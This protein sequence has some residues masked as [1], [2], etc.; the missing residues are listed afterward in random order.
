MHREPVKTLKHPRL[1]PITEVERRCGAGL[2]N[3]ITDC[4][5]R[6]PSPVSLNLRFGIILCSL[7]VV[8]VGLVI[9]F[10]TYSARLAEEQFVRQG[11]AIAASL[12]AQSAVDV[13]MRDRG[14]LTE[15]LDAWINSGVISGGVLHGPGGS[16]LARRNFQSSSPPARSDLRRSSIQWTSDSEEGHLLIA[17][18]PVVRN[19]RHLGSVS[20]TISASAVAAQRDAGLWM[21]LIVSA[22]LT[23]LTVI[24]LVMLN[25][26]VVRPLVALRR[27][28]RSAASGE[29]PIRIE[30]YA[31]DEVGQLA[32]WFDEMIRARERDIR[33]LQDQS[34]HVSQA[35]RRSEA[36]QRKT[37][38]EAA[39]L[40]NQFDRLAEITAHVMHG[41][42]TRHLEVERD[43]HVGDLMHQINAMVGDLSRMISRIHH[44]AHRMTT[45]AVSV[46]SSAEVMS[47]GARDQSVRACTLADN[48]HA[49][50]D[51]A[52]KVAR[53]VS[54]VSEQA[55]SALDVSR[56]SL[57]EC[58]ASADVMRRVRDSLNTAADTAGAVNQSAK[59][60]FDALSA[61]SE[62]ADQIN[63]LAFNAAIEAA[64]AGDQGRGFSVVADQ[65]TKV[66]ERATAAVKNISTISD[67]LRRDASA[68]IEQTTRESEE[69][70][71]ALQSVDAV[72]EA[73]V[74]LANTIP[75]LEDSLNRIAKH[76][77]DNAA[78]A[79]HVAQE[80][81]LVADFSTSLSDA[82]GE[83]ARLSDK[84]GLHAGD[85]GTL[86][87]R[88]RIDRSDTGNGDSH[89][90]YSGRN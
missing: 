47:S 84:M 62:I 45:A 23:L 29:S 55:H 59:H 69:V 15:R 64:R 48:A 61:F 79:V 42:L 58:E 34:R 3:N 89:G 85:I 17:S 12:A 35:L 11:Q 80:V 65:M 16:T 6:P 50:A 90:Y 77:G 78:A 26:F 51:E 40:Q 8:I 28:A 30:T 87:K 24:L 13:M 4:I 33:A 54:Q 74:A 53:D 43:D 52:S 86:I 36:L 1:C 63:L 88:F 20:L 70:A 82:T 73:V 56:R 9:G 14:G 25:V 67:H 72:T 27:T 81:R 19:G 21:A 31:D 32:D 66:S 49:L 71:G 76:S 10:A 41:D 37:D 38:A 39:Y 18:H 57:N 60:V 75:L 7:S 83:F 68:I 46:A 44:A 5:A 22:T 2:I